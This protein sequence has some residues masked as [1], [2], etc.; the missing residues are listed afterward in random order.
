MNT[1][2]VTKPEPS[3][4]AV[5]AFF[6]EPENIISAEPY[7]T[8]LINDTYLIR[9]RA[10]EDF[11][12]QR[13]N[14]EVFP[15]PTKLLDNIRRISSHL[16]NKA[17]TTKL[18]PGQPIL[19]LLPT[20][21]GADCCYDRENDCWRALNFIGESRVL[22][23]IT[24]EAQAQGAGLALGRFQALVNDFPPAE[25]YDPLPTL[26]VTPCALRAYDQLAAAY[27]GSGAGGPKAEIS[28]CHDFIERRRHT[29]AVLEQA[30]ARGILPERVIHGDPKLA[31]ILF[32]QYSDH[33]L[34]LIDLDTVKPG[35]TQYDVGDCLRSCCNRA[36][37]N[38]A[39]P[40]EV[41][42]DLD[43]ARAL[44][45]GYLEEMRAL[46]TYSD[47]SYFY[48]AA[49]LISFELGIRF[50]SDYLDGNRYFKVTDPE[51]NL[52]RALTQFRLTASIEDQEELLR[53]IINE[54]TW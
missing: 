51:H 44:L 50:F 22:P 4:A 29:A 11:L 54:L 20:R 13:L 52:H 34:A 25:L 8:G 31:N 15:Q 9:C 23:R 26:H 39:N 30:R 7:G 40:D 17:R 49:R 18:A 46:L 45:T 6:T 21:E 12:L 5:A 16:S 3:A 42:F 28:F 10:G 1:E 53:L 47:F 33:P 37:E 48:D 24:S 19:H 41:E 36:G 43:L 27:H 14:P 38:P 2:S 32:A 35:L